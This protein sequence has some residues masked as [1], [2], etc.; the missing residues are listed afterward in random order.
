LRR[1]YHGATE[2]RASLPELIAPTV[3]AACPLVAADPDE[4]IEEVMALE[5]QV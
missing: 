1:S 2:H 4:G 3:D 5:A